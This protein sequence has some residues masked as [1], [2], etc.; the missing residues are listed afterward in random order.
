MADEPEN[1]AMAMLLRLE[2]RLESLAEEF[3]RVKGRLAFVESRLARLE[4]ECSALAAPDVRTQQA[5]EHLLLQ[6]AE[7]AP[8]LSP[9][10]DQDELAEAARAIKARRTIVYVL[11]DD[12]REALDAA[13][14]AGIIS[15]EEVAAFWRRRGRG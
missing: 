12:E 6:H 7:I 15:H 5:I 2:A 11:S 1:R 3:L 8:P 10:Q 14:R 13:L 9:G 4:A